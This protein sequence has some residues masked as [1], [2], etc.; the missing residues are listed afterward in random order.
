M[1]QRLLGQLRRFSL[2][3]PD[4]VET[5]SWGH[6]NF[7]AGKKTFA[8]YEIYQGRPCIAVKLPAPE[9]ERLLADPRFYR[10]PYTGKHG[11]VS[12][13]VDHPVAWSLV[14]SLVLTSYREVATKRQV[15]LLAGSRRRVR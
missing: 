1:T 5:D 15:A 14:K 4:G 2:S 10:T 3:L 12:L 9:G 8:V 13:L 6:P 7:R 11:W